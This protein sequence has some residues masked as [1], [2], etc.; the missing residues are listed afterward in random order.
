MT[1]FRLLIL[2]GK[3][4]AET[5]VSIQGW[6]CAGWVQQDV[7]VYQREKACIY[8]DSTQKNSQGLVS[9]HIVP[10]DP[11]FRLKVDCC[12]AFYFYYQAMSP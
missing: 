7:E 1:I 10:G 5:H 12:K 8:L 2:V 3:T 6:G 9:L 4:S 11:E